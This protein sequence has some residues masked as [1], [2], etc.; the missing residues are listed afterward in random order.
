MGLRPQSCVPSLSREDRI[1]SP[2]LPIA[3]GGGTHGTNVWLSAARA[4]FT[5]IRYSP[6][7]Q[8][9]IRIQAPYDKPHRKPTRRIRTER[10]PIARGDHDPE[11]IEWLC[12]VY[13]RLFT[14]RLGWEEG[15]QFDLA[16]TDDDNEAALPQM[17]GPSGYVPELLESTY[18]KNAAAIA[19]Q[20]FGDGMTD[21]VGE[22]MIYKPA[23]RGAATPWHQDQAY[24]DPTL[25][26]K[27][28][29]FWMSLDGATV[30][31]GCLQ[32]VPGSHKMD[33]LSHHSINH[34]PRIHGLEVD[35]PDQWADK[36]VPC[37]LP[38]GGATI[39]ACY[40]LHCAEPNISD[41][42]HRAYTLTFRCE[43]TLRDVPIDNYWRREQN[44]ARQ[45][46]A[47]NHP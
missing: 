8:I 16:G 42:P 26:Y 41:R 40:L 38:V 20:I 4:V 22:H 19:R 46:R 7:G 31:S 45:Q 35:D 21:R 33:V 27:G 17:L 10:L 5:R 12:E 44:T 28:V 14:D 2:G 24:H 11:K 15:S 39:H 47:D 25:A 23:G 3:E 18:R 13:D 6:L 30:D 29:N 43:L 1:S 36:A 32:F 9:E 34:D 37:P